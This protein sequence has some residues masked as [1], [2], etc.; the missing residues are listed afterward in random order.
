MV[1]LIPHTIL[2]KINKALETESIDADE[3]DYNK[4]DEDYDLEVFIHVGDKGVS[5]LGHVDLWF[6]GTVMTYGSYDADTFKLNGLISDGVLIE[7]KDKL[8]YI[9]FSK[10]YMGKTL[11]GF[12]LK[13]A[14]WVKQGLILL[15]SKV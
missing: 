8:K 4:G 1:A 13:I 6:E 10:K 12:G 11:F 9:E 2:K 15:K 14:L 3:L 7:M 5:K